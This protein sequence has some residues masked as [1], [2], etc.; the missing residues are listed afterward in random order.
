[1]TTCVR[2]KLLWD[3]CE[4]VFRKGIAGD[5]V[6]CG[7]WKGG[8]A[9][10]MGI[11][12]QQYDTKSI[13]KLHLFDS[14]EGLPE[15]REE[16]G[17][18]AKVYSGGVNTGALTSVHQCEAGIEEV[19]DL[20]FNILQLQPDRFVFHKG[21]FQ[22]TIPNLGNEPKQIAL[23]R[24]DG[25]WYESTKICLDHLY[26]RVSPGG[27]IIM[28][29]YYCWEGCRKATNEFR[30]ARG[31]TDPVHEIDVDAGYWIKSN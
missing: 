2:S 10:L 12:A 25:D 14:F 7:V 28:D 18:A 16:D 27:A 31:I 15:P 11:A 13:R 3:L 23:L 8:S 24:L 30:A 22:D 17:D 5:F 29:D 6:E 1:M 9:G 20:I 19:Q 21:W 26:D 4:N